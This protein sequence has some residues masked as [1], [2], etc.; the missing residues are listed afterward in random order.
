ME[1]RSTRENGAGGENGVHNEG[2]E[3]TETNED[4]AYDWLFYEAQDLR[5]F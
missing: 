3:L 2:T 5:T 4:S 1:N